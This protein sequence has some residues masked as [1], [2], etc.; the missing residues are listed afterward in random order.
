MRLL[1]R[2]EQFFELFIQADRSLDYATLD[3]DTTDNLAWSVV[4]VVTADG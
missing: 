2:D 3:P 1:P 4:A